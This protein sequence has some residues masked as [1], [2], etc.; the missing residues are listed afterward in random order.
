MALLMIVLELIA[1]MFLA[2][3][4]L[5]QMRNFRSYINVGFISTRFSG[6]FMIFKMELFLL[7]ID[8][9][10]NEDEVVKI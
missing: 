7:G 8:C 5:C 6:Y 1:K 3:K 2:M 10:V 4:S 9:N